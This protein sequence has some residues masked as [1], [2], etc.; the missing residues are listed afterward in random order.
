QSNAGSGMSGLKE[1]LERIG[2]YR[3]REKVAHVASLADHA[4]DRCERVRLISVSGN[5]H[6]RNNCA[7]ATG[8][9]GK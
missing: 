8:L 2:I 1:A 5:R 7:A 6:G 3:E 9:E 4:I